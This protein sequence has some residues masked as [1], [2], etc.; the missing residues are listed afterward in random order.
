MTKED[1]TFVADALL[2]LAAE[3]RHAPFHTEEALNAKMRLEDARRA[4][5][6]EI[7]AP[8]QCFDYLIECECRAILEGACLTQ[9]QMDVLKLRLAGRRFEEIGR[10]R[11]HTKQG[12]QRIFVQAIKKL[13]R[14]YHVYRYRGLS[15][16][17]R[18][19]V[20]RGPRRGFGTMQ[21]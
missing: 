9:I 15:D 17:Y 18:N 14:S 20:N 12:A 13:S 6:A 8:D 3:D 16:V 10:L 19:E 1:L 21:P 7:I 11:S 5:F 4:T 2:A